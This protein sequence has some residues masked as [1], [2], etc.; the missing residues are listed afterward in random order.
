MVVLL[1]FY[2]LSGVDNV[3]CFFGKGK[4]ICWKVFMEVDDEIID[5][6]F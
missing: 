6:F 4:V 2:V 5:C 1:V 3:G